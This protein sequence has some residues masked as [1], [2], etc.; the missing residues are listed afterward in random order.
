MSLLGAG[1]NMCT[2][3]TP[4]DLDLFAICCHSKVNYVLPQQNNPLFNQHY[5]VE[6]SA[7]DEIISSSLEK[8]LWIY[9]LGK[10]ILRTS[11]RLCAGTVAPLEC[12]RLLVCFL[13]LREGSFMGCNAS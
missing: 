8:V 1:A 2:Q 12:P 9:S 13:V 11:I 3:R 6:Y 10:P 5:Y 4:F 7:L